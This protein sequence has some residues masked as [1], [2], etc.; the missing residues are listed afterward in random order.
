MGSI[1]E[2]V[3]LLSYLITRKP[4]RE[5]PA[6]NGPILSARPLS[7]YQL[8]THAAPKQQ[9]QLETANSEE[10]LCGCKRVLIVGPRCFPFRG[11]ANGARVFSSASSKW[12]RIDQ[13]GRPD[14][15]QLSYSARHSVS[16]LPTA[17]SYATGNCRSGT[18]MAVRS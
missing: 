17:V 3:A 4:K 1:Q 16:S 8:P 5:A 15:V 10:N 7:K 12:Q 11:P 13:K 9:V 6:F 18:I 2:P 14:W